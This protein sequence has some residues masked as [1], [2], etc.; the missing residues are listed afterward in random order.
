M[1][2]L[3]VI[4]L[5]SP[6]SI[7]FSLCFP[8]Y[9]VYPSPL[10]TY[11]Y[12]FSLLLYFP[13]SH[14]RSRTSRLSRCSFPSLSLTH[15][16]Y[17]PTRFPHLPSSCQTNQLSLWRLQAGLPRGQSRAGDGI[18]LIWY[19]DRHLDTVHPLN[20]GFAV[21]VPTLPLPS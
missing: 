21:D 2:F 11:F 1:L 8:T 7:S 3:F 19:A 4:I 15:S 16:L 12:S 14:Q 20:P 10:F 18:S 9:A 5:F 6:L 13:G 17:R